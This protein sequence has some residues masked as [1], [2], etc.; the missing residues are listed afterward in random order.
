MKKEFLFLTLLI[1]SILF[2]HGGGL[3]KDGCHNDRKTG[4]YH[5]HR[6]PSISP[7][8][9]QPQQHS[10]SEKDIARFWC[11]ARE[12]MNEFRT[13][14]GTYVDCLTAKYA[15]EVEYDNNWKEA[16]GQSLH[17]AEATGKSPAILLIKRKSSNKDYYQELSKVITQYQL[18]IKVYQ[19]QE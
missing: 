10:S 19:I 8:L 13:K 14:Y 15:V 7:N 11:S 5:C 3:N 16:I 18:P 9:T 17:Y 1:P 12:G 4:G 2:S 6:S